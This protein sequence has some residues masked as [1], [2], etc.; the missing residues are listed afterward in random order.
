MNSPDAGHTMQDLAGFHE[1]L[2]SKKAVVVSKTSCTFCIRAK[3]IL[4]SATDSLEI[5]ETDKITEGKKILDE[6]REDTGHRTLPIIYLGG[7]FIGGC[8]SLVKLEKSGELYTRLGVARP[9]DAWKGNPTLREAPF[10][11]SLLWFPHTVNIYP[12]RCIAFLVS[13]IAAVVCAFY[14]EEWAA[15]VTFGLA[16]DFI[17]RFIGGAFFSPIGAAALFFTAGFKEDLRGGAPKQ[18]ATFIGICFTVAATMC[19]LNGEKI[20]GLVILCCLIGAA[21]LEAVFDFCAGCV[22]F[23][24]LIKFGLIRESVNQVFI[25]S[26]PLLENAISLVDDFSSNLKETENFTYTEL[27]Q[28]RTAADVKVKRFK[29]D[30]HVRRSFSPIRY[31]EISD[32]MMPLGITGLAAAWRSAERQRNTHRN[33]YGPE[34]MWQIISYIGG[35]IG[36]FM[37]IALLGKTILYPRKV[38]K[39]MIHPIK[40]NFIATLP[41]LLCILSFLYEPEDSNKHERRTRKAM[42]WIGAVLLKVLLLYKV[43]WLVG[44][45]A[46]D[47]VITPA[48]L[49]PLGGCLVASLVSPLLDDAG[50]THYRE[51]GWFFFGFSSL[52][53]ILMFGGTF[54]Q[55]IKYH[56]SDERIRS[57]IGM[58]PTVLLLIMI[59]YV[60]L[61]NVDPLAGS[62]LR[63]E[64]I[65]DPFVNVFFYSGITLSLVML[66]L[67][68][69]MGFLFRMKFDFSMWSIAFTADIVAIACATYDDLK[70]GGTESDS[71]TGFLLAGS[72]GTATW[73]VVTLFFQTL[74]MLVKKRWLRAPYKWAPLSFNKLSHVALREAGAHLL[75]EAIAISKLEDSEHSAVGVGLGRDIQMYFLVFKWHSHM[76]DNILFR[77]IDGFHPLITQDGYLQH[78]ELEQLEH[79]LLQCGTS[80]ANGSSDATSIVEKTVAILKDLVPYADKHMD[81]E[82]ENLNSLLR[83]GFNLAVQK[84]LVSEVWETYASKSLEEILEEKIPV[85]GE[86][87]NYD[88]SALSKGKPVFPSKSA[89][90]EE[91]L[92]FPPKLPTEPIPFAKQQI[93]RVVLPYMVR[94]L[95]IPMQKTRFVRSLAWAIPENAQ[96]IG[97]MVY[98]GVDDSTWACLAADVPECVP[99]GLPGWVRRI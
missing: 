1:V 60:Q 78:A 74:F 40:S 50:E 48:I 98:R 83:K 80:L 42:F 5:F 90:K 82:E 16:M 77:K 39:E 99:R 26:K 9:S 62:N 63:T 27:N 67:A 71:Y 23:G 61:A 28:P 93:L 30:D 75:Q 86:W 79:Q 95:P 18:F 17:V 29:N 31:I 55:A 73:I 41:M 4:E 52:L 72:I 8:D 51:V 22:V 53:S 19:F 85:E 66:W 47:E 84:K 11:A 38:Y 81:W 21:M 91:L 6:A 56:W 65:T 14:E 69:P 35:A 13:C 97:D 46:D 76:E 24:W 34:D 59:S 44:N 92:D 20:A 94:W 10:N 32:F 68:V 3:S 54:L 36:G 64:A 43:S 58:W 88:F 49:M 37:F 15:W 89:T 96:L 87:N 12:V 70:Q 33:G 25:D 7:K 2:K 57:S 45:R